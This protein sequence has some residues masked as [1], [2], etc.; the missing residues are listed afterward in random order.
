MYQQ[1]Y[2]SRANTKASCESTQN[3]LFIESLK[4]YKTKDS[5]HQTQPGKTEEKQGKRCCKRQDSES[6]WEP[7]RGIHNGEAFA[8]LVEKMCVFTSLFS[9]LCTST[10]YTYYV[11]HNCKSK[12][13]SMQKKSKEV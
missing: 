8:K 10:T 11:S 6:C 12:E 3:G 5:V 13:H 4:G 9:E 2:V 1:G 7:G